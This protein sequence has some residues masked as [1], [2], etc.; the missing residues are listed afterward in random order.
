MNERIIIIGA[1]MGGLSSSIALAGRSGAQIT[2][3]EAASGPGGKI[4]YGEHSGVR[5]DTGPSILTLPEIPRALFEAQGYDFDKEIKLVEST[6]NFRYYYPDGTALD[7]FNTLEETSKNI[8]KTLGPKAKS[9]F[10]AFMTYARRIWTAAAPNFIMGPA[11]NFGSMVRLGLGAIKQLRD[12]DPMRSMAQAIESKISD[13]YLRSIFLRYATYNGSDPRKAPATL[14]CI[15]WVELGMGCWGIAGGM[16]Q[17]AAT[18]ERISRDKGTTFRYDSPVR[19]VTRNQDGTFLVRLDG[20]DLTANAVIVNA[21]VAHLV[22]DLLGPDDD[23]GIKPPEAASMSA[24]NAVI[25]ARRRP[26]AR[27]PGHA[28]VFPDRDYMEEFIDI[29]DHHRAPLKPT[30]YLCAQE[31]AHASEGWADH[32][33]LFMMANAP[34]LRGPD[35]EAFDWAAYEEAIVT[36]LR[37]L[38]LIDHDDEVIWT[39]QPS[40]L[41]SRFPG[42]RG[43]LYGA[44]SNSTFDAFRRPAN[45]SAQ[46]PGLYLA[47]GSAH[48]G[49]GVPLC[50]QSGRQAALELIKDR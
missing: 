23:S 27:R 26:A 18:M 43:S 11:P 34:P 7:I 10:D 8:E 3:I 41:A 38:D 24:W 39:R 1:G 25:K 35:D 28:V 4:G 12:I 13:P 30:I 5:F 19:S 46:I 20:E 45:R 40:G 16:R 2:V 17:L 44:A 37:T 6:P 15:S 50:I 29:F 31:K 48:P 32:E 14:S 22:K 47:G 33:P 42:S 9:E 36:R 21:D 49:G